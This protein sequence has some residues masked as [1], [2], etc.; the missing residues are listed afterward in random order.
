MSWLPRVLKGV[1][2]AFAV[3][4]AATHVISIFTASINW[5]EFMLFGRAERSLASG[6]LQGGGRPGLGVVALMP[7]VDGCTSSIEVARTAR[8]AWSLVT[9]ALL[10]GLFVFLRHACHRS[11]RAWEAAA[12][13][14]A[15]LACVPL[16]VRWSLHVRTDQPALAAAI[17]GGVALFAARRRVG[18]A[19]LAGVLFAVG[20]LF[21]QKAVYIVALVGLVT[22]G[23][24]YLEGRIQ[25]RREA[26]R[27]AA[28]VA[29]G[30]AVVGSY[31]YVLPLFYERPH[32][33][34]VDEGTSLFSWLRMALGYRVYVDMLP[35]V[36]P[37]LLALALLAAA[38][39]V[40]LR[41]QLPARK[42]L[43]VALGCAVL[44]L[45]V[46]KFHAA[47]FPYFWMTLGLFFATA[48]AI[49]WP[50]L[51]EVWPRARLGLGVI[52]AA[53]MLYNFITA[54][55]ET[56]ADTQAIQR[57]TFAFIDRNF[58][59][60]HR[61]FHAHSALYCRRDPDPL[62]GR[63]VEATLRWFSGPLGKQHTDDFLREFRSRP[64]SLL[65]LPNQIGNYPPEI[66]AFWDANYQ[67]YFYSVRVAGRRITKSEDVEIVVTGR[68]RYFTRGETGRITVDGTPLAR[69]D[70][71][72]LT[73]GTHRVVVVEALTEGLLV[74]DVA[75]PP[76]VN[77]APF[78]TSSTDSSWYDARAAKQPAWSR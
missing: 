7:F 14:V 69:G 47:A 49:A 3:A 28:I 57:E 61:G 31:R 58:D 46:G 32:V 24:L 6:Q 66:V 72:E 63:L 76:R 74:L 75:D 44:G 35:T 27:V 43:L 34:S 62:P 13:G 10:G 4:Y 5:D 18:W 73:A 1:L 77:D 59:A 55:A 38:A 54:R 71:I 11:P 68:Y 23:D 17:W 19:A 50:A 29:G 64:V 42:T 53:G 22:L 65:V 25:V 9:F 15:L 45:A 60:R 37:H 39:V 16:F 40:A 33:F 12:V 52:V 36:I 70:T 51:G 56:L 2:I 26:M 67:P 20:Y 41:R 78:Y 8:I 30:V 48:I 21:S